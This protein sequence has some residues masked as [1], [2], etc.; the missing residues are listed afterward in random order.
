MRHIAPLFIAIAS[1]G[2]FS[3]GSAQQAA[4]PAPAP[5]T[6]GLQISG[7]RLA[8]LLKAAV[9]GSADPAVAEVGVSEQY[10]IHEVHRGKAGPAAIHMGWSEVHLVLEGGG[11]LVTGGK[12][13]DTAGGSKSIEGG[14]SHELKKGDVFIVPSNTPHMY[15]KVD[16]SLTY[17]ELRFPSVAPK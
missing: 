12:M 8:E 10:Q 6:P 5:G 9:A 2:L 1:T 11:T 17:F 3:T 4:P 14:V 13:I 15:S 16:G 7:Q